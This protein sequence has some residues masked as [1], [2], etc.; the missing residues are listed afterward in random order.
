MILTSKFKKDSITLIPNVS[1]IS[2]LRTLFRTQEL[3]NELNEI[4]NEN[5]EAPLTEAT[6]GK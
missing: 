5:I 6:P 3:K 4:K 1:T 2:F